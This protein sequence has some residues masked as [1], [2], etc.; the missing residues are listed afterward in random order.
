MRNFRPSS[1]GLLVRRVFSVMI[2]T[3]LFVPT[4]GTLPAFA[5]TSVVGAIAV[6]VSPN[7]A[8]NV[9][10][11]TYTVEFTTSSTGALSPSSTITVAAPTGT[12]LTN[13]FSVDD[14]TTGQSSPEG[15]TAIN[16]STAAID[17]N[18]LTISG[19]DQVIV[20]LNNVTNPPTV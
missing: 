8:V 1:R 17:T 2:L 11:V 3:G 6:A 15:A 13:S 20:T 10:G 9:P 14:V 19:G 18:G 16:G 7:N 12:T 4:V 5:A